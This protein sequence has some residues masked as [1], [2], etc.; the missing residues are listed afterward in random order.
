MTGVA[1]AWHEFPRAYLGTALP[2]FPNL[3][4]VTGP[5]TGIGHTSAIFIIGPYRTL[6]S[7]CNVCDAPVPRI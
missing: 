3:F 5:N 6:I 2:D 1:D 4:I 7:V